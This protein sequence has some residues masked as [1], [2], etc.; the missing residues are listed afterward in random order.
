MK[1]LLLGAAIGALL[2][3]LPAQALAQAASTGSNT[4]TGIQT[5]NPGLQAAGSYALNVF[6]TQTN[7]HTGGALQVVKKAGELHGISLMEESYSGHLLDWY[8][9]TGQRDGY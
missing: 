4:F 3:Q 5:I 2:V 7:N 8:D 9:P 1:R 6:G